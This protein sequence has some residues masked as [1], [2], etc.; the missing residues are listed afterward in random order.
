MPAH[1]GHEA[2]KALLSFMLLIFELWRSRALTTLSIC[3]SVEWFLGKLQSV[4][5]RRYKACEN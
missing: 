5:K 4:L 3:L 2:P 1:S